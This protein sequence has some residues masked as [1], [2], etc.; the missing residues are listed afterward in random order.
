MLLY[1]SPR[2]LRSKDKRHSERRER[3]KLELTGRES[4]SWTILADNSMKD[5]SSAE[6]VTFVFDREADSYENMT[7]LRQQTACEFI[8]RQKYDRKAIEVINGRQGTIGEML[9]D[10]KWIGVQTVK[11]RKLNHYSHTKGKKRRRKKRKA[12]L[13][14]RYLKVHLQIPGDYYKYHPGRPAMKEPLYL[15]EVME[16]ES[17]V[18]KGEQPIRWKLWTTWKVEDA[19]S[20]WEVVDAYRARWNVEQ[21]FRLLKKGGINLENSQLR[22]PDRVKRLLIMA[23]IA[24]A[25]ALRLVQARDG[26]H[27]IPINEMFSDEEQALLKKL[28]AKLSK[29][30]SLVANHHASNS[31]AFAAWII[32]RLGGWNGYQSQ[33]PPGPI[34]MH[35]GLKQFYELLEWRDILSDP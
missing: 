35:R 25:Q 21:L 27:F 3:L 13:K 15:V 8:I 23:T 14:I 11:I 12:R 4:G 34:K 10:Q 30:G 24:S 29:K 16:D 28:N 33:R 19:K 1:D 9:T 6:Q 5:L 26:E 20:A 2:D 17:T 7:H 31:L 32:A 18:P 22:H